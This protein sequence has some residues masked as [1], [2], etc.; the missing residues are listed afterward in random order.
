MLRVL[1]VDDHQMFA[2]SLVRLLEDDH[3]L[4]VVGIAATC[5]ET[6]PAIL[7]QRPGVVV[8]DH[9]LPDGVGVEAAAR[10]RR[11]HPSV[12]IVMLTGQAD[13]AL[14][15]EA[16]EA[17]CAGVVTKDR[18]VIDLVAAVRAAERGE[19]F[20]VAGAS[21]GLSSSEGHDP[22]S[23]LSARELEVVRLL[24]RGC[25]NQEI[26]AELHLSVNTV[27]NH[28]RAVL[29]KLAVASRLEAAAAALRLGLVAPPRSTP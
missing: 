16:I 25:S 13:A 26:A 21:R 5:A 17:G 15:G 22:G 23:R 28:L 9:R 24:V 10:L 8:L 4:E 3:D 14:V 12:Q 19:T 7:S 11:D 29:R 6:E 18:A 20:F 27:R 1:I 2:E